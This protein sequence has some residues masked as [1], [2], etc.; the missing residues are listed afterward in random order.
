[1]IHL[2]GPLLN[3]VTEVDDM[4]CSLALFVSRNLS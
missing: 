2:P 4:F 1:V 3:K